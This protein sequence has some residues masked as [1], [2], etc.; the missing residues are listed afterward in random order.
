[1]VQHVAKLIQTVKKVVPKCDNTVPKLFQNVTKLLQNVAKFV[2]KFRQNG[3]NF[4][5]IFFN[6]PQKNNNKKL[7]SSFSQSR[8]NG[9][10]LQTCMGLFPFLKR[11]RLYWEKRERLQLIRVNFLDQ[12]AAKGVNRILPCS[13]SLFFMDPIYWSTKPCDD[14]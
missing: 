2:S 12:T 1:M 7:L 8:K 3:T 9:L 10:L 6:C 5:S 14:P 4:L 13:S 11:K